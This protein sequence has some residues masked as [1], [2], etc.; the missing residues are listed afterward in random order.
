MLSGWSIC[1]LAGAD[2]QLTRALAE[3][4]RVLRADGVMIILETLRTRY[5]TPYPPEK[6]KAYYNYLKRAAFSSAWIRTDYRFERVA[7]AVALTGF[8]FDPEMAHQVAQRQQTI[9]PECT[10]IWWCWAYASSPG[11]PSHG[12]PFQSTAARLSSS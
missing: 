11:L 9:V 8:F 3:M 7:E 6:L 1:Y 4:M 10:G 2:P 5:E 12:K